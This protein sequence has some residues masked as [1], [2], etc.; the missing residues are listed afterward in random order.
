LSSLERVHLSGPF[1]TALVKY[2]LRGAEAIRSLALGIEW[3]DPAFCSTQPEGRSDYLGK[4]Y[5]VRKPR[6]QL[7]PYNN[8]LRTFDQSFSYILFGILFLK[9]KKEL[10]FMTVKNISLTWL[11]ISM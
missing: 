10:H 3:L 7:L 11:A 5:L 2:L 8:R 4:E 9:L 1:G 6:P